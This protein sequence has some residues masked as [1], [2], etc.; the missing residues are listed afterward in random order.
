MKWRSNFFLKI[1]FSYS[2]ET[3]GERQ[4]E[5]QAE[6]EAGSLRGARCGTRSWSRDRGITPWAEGRCSTTEPPRRPGGLIF[7]MNSRL[8]SSWV[9]GLFFLSYP[10]SFLC[11]ELNPQL[12]DPVSSLFRFRHWALSF[13]RSHGCDCHTLIRCGNLVRNLSSHIS[14]LFSKLFSGFFCDV[15]PIRAQNLLVT[16]L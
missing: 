16:F 10:K 1:L 15:S 13:V 3:Q 14:F 9:I 7:W 12:H 2:W 4:V 8:S 6:G 11:H 5:T